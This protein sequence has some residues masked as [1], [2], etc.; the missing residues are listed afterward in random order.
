MKMNP[1][2]HF[3]IPVEEMPR[4]QEFYEQVFGWQVQA[5]PEM[6]GQYHMAITVPT[7]ETGPTEPG[8]IN[9]ALARECEENPYRAWLVI[10]VDSVDEHVRKVEAAGGRL[11]TEKASV[12]GMGFYA[13]VEDTE[14]NLIGLWESV[15]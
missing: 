13:E 9:G 11:V 4:A 1:V 15:K 3:Q 14:G 7:G 10:G 8:G 5:P 2:M 6:E 12:M